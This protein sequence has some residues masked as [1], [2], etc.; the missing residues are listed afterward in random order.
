MLQVSSTLWPARMPEVDSFSTIHWQTYWILGCHVVVGWT[1]GCSPAH[2]K[3]LKEVSYISVPEST[4]FLSSKNRKCKFIAVGLKM[5]PKRQVTEHFFDKPIIYRLFQCCYTVSAQ[6]VCLAVTTLIEVGIV[7]DI[8]L[9]KS[10]T[11]WEIV[12]STWSPTL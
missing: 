11:N 9:V 3:L 6:R 8:S 2:H 1:P 4:Q 12:S 10:N 7:T 5:V